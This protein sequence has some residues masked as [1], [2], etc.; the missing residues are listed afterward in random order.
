MFVIES[1]RYYICIYLKEDNQTTII[2]KKVFLILFTCI[3]ATGFFSSCKKCR[4]CE[5]YGPSGAYVTQEYCGNN[6]QVNDWEDTWTSTYSYSY[7]WT[8]NCYDK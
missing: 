7:G 1:E 2:M 8:T 5:A 6:K 4:V 3:L